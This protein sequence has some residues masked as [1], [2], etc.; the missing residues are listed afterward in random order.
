[1]NLGVVL[2]DGVVVYRWSGENGARIGGA[3]CPA[4]RVIG[5]RSR[6]PFRRFVC[7]C[8]TSNM[9]DP[10]GSAEDRRRTRKVVISDIAMATVWPAARPEKSSGT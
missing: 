3:I 6:C 8:Y 2:G 9:V 5:G 1:M 4:G 7:E 10:S